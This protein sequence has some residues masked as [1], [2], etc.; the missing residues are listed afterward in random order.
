MFLLD[1]RLAV[2][3]ARA[4]AAV[5][6]A[7][8]AGRRPAA[9]GDRRAAGLA[10]GRV[11]DRAGVALGLGDPARQDD[12]PLGRAGRALR[13][14]VEPARRPRGAQPHDGPLDDGRDPDDLRGHARARL[15]VRG[16]YDG[17]GSETISIGTLVAFTTLQSRLFFPIGSLLGVQVDVQSS[18]ALFDRIFEYL[19]QP[20]DIDGGHADAGATRAATSPSSTSGSA[21][22]T[23]PG[24]SRT[25]TSR[26][27][28]GTKT[29]LVG[30]TG[31]GKTT[32]RATSSRGSTT[33][34]RGG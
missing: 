19:D 14:R 32:L 1:W 29:A 21:T 9:E 3:R 23:R 17:D 18:L 11:L 31:S 10:R 2:V 16:L 24:R 6:L 7:D 34:P 5:R 8:E 28:P 27:R 30:E 26:C 15:L 25:S 33:P 12:G 13:R 4:A 22:G 20:V